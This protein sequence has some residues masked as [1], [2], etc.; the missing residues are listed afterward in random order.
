MGENGHS[1]ADK[2]NDER[3]SVDPSCMIQGAGFILCLAPNTSADPPK[4]SNDLSNSV[5]DE[6]NEQHIF[7]PAAYQETIINMMERHY[8]TH[9][10]IPGYAALDAS[11]I[12]LWAVKQMY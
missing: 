3:P 10:M 7:C 2:E 9:P 6:G 8:C 12:K 5:E 4:E 11:A 1:T